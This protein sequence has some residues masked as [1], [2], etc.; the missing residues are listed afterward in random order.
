MGISGKVQDLIYKY[1]NN[2]LNDNENEYQTITI[3]VPQSTILGPPILII[4]VNN[5]LQVMS[6]D[7]IM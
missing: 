1:L 7:W 3:R 4:Y 2:K 5:A 6:E